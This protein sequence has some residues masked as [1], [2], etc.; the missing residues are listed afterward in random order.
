MKASVSLSTFHGGPSSPMLFMEDLE[1]NIPLISD[2]G[3]EGV[4]LFV[5]DP[6]D[7]EVRKAV[8][9]LEKYSLGVGVVMPA[10]LSSMHLTMGDENKDVRD[11]FL[12]RITKIID[13]ASSLN[14]M[15]SR[16]L[17]RGSR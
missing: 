12:R 9:L 13:F 7:E 1:N 5:I 4:D 8:V 17:V 11:E 14:S 6:D 16:G 10:G 15:V 2:L 3:Y